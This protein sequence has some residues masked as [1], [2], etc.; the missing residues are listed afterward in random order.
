MWTNNIVLLGT[1]WKTF[2]LH[3]YQ[4]CYLVWSEDVFHMKSSVKQEQRYHTQQIT[5]SCFH[6]LFLKTT[7]LWNS[8]NKLL[9]ATKK[10]KKLTHKDMFFYSF[11][12]NGCRL[13]NSIMTF[14]NTHYFEFCVFDKEMCEDKLKKNQKTIC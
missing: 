7:T 5:Y 1:S 2:I 11:F 12:K 10:K 6:F 8:L 13:G 9:I 3:A 4:I 14:I